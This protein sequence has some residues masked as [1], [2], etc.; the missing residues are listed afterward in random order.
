MSGE[1][2]LIRRLTETG[3]PSSAAE[4]TASVS[5]AA[6]DPEWDAFLGGRPGA[7]HAQASSWGRVK[8]LSGWSASRVVLREG[9]GI[10]AGGQLFTKTLM[11]LG[12]AGYMPMGP[13][14][15]EER[16]ELTGRLLSEILALARSRGVQLLSVQPAFESASLDRCLTERGFR[17]SW[18]QL[19][20]S[21]TSVVDLS[22][23][24]DELLAR[25]V[26]KTGKS[27][28]R[29]EREG[30]A[31]REGGAADLSDF[32]RLHELTARRQKFL[33]YP[34]AYFTHMWE[35]LKPRE[36]IDLIV[37]EHGGEMVS[38]LWLVAFGS[39][40]YA[41]VLGWSGRLPE[42]RPNQALFWGAI[43]ISK[44]KGR[45]TFDFEGIDRHGAEELLC[46]RPL[47]EK[48][49]F[50]P[51]FLKIGFGGRIV[52]RPRVR[53]FVRNP[54]LRWGYRRFS[55]AAVRGSGSFTALERFRRRFGS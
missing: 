16:V 7:Y 54:V 25:C 8:A 38:A 35:I 28:R 24:L 27:I 40:A 23:G 31:V 15:P 1:D 44:E 30:I 6:D 50:S 3:A 11:R 47:P 12:R 41:K 52:L 48:L 34:K 2:L 4:T 10:V 13:V 37:A 18:L 14:F 49:R 22:P 45:R 29:A 42:K 36:E 39:T 26:H 17:P 51:D 32:V 5:T 20:P 43:R 9:G 55:E 33:P 53:D 46:G 19:C 21:A